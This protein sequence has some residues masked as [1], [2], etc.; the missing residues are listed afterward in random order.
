MADPKVKTMHYLRSLLALAALVASLPSTAEV[1]GP[2]LLWCL[3]EEERKPD[4][5]NG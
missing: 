5:S 1:V 2:K 3:A 4:F